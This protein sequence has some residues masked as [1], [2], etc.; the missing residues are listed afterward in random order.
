MS[1][2]AT[3][4]APPTAPPIPSAKETVKELSKPKEDFAAK[5]TFLMP[6]VY[7]GQHILWFPNGDMNK[8]VGAI[9]VAVNACNVNLQAA[10]GE[11]W[12]YLDGVRHKD[13]PGLVLNPEFKKNGV[14][15]HTPETQWVREMSGTAQS[16]K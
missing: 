11:R 10:I 9:V 12:I 15:E 3:P 2:S 1:Q 14:W 7:N 6:Q 5:P 16:K 8:P 4:S 13:D